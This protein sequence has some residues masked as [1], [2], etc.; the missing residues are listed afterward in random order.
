MSRAKLYKIYILLGVLALCCALTFVVSRQE[1][2]K[3]LIKNSDE[4]ILTLDVEGV[5]SL[6]WEYEDA[7]LAF[8]R[9]EQWLYDED[10]AFPVDEEKIKKLLEV[11]EEFGVAFVIDEVEDYSQYGLEDPTCT[12]EISTEENSYEILLGGYSTMDEKR[13]VSIGDGRVYLVSSDPFEQYEA[14]LDD[15]ICHDE[16]PDLSGMTRLTFSG[17]ENYSIVYEED[18][19]NTYCEDDVYFMNDKPLAT[20]AV[21]DYLEIVEKLGL[22]D[23]VSYNVTEEELEAFGL[24]EPELTVTVEYLSEEETE[25]EEVF[26][27]H[28][29][30]N[31]EELQAAEESEEEGAEYSVT[32]YV[33]VGESQIVYEIT[34]IN[35]IRLTAAS[36]DDLRH[37]EVLT[38]SFDDIFEI[39][40]TLENETYTFTKKTEENDTAW[41]YQDEIVDTYSLRSAIT[42]MEADSFTQEEPDGREEISFTVFLDNE[43]YPSVTVLLYRYDGSDCIAVIDGEI[44]SLVPREAVVKLIEAVYALVL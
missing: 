42:S 29:G 20:E 4:I 25:E 18:S 27:L 2:K 21:S 35:Y 19:V 14:E 7:A 22:L 13:Y 40:L 30:R 28:V 26:V 24:T 12:I 10:E 33:R 43:A 39:E 15:L 37:K 36:Y 34:S 17:M 3:E 32:A 44:V 41:Y 16:I 23:Y 9:E 6:S 31:Q 1:E 5:T 8:H 11:F 38:A